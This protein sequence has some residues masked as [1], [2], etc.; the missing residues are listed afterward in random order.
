MRREKKLVVSKE[1]ESSLD[2]V[3]VIQEGS[4]FRYTTSREVCP[5]LPY[6]QVDCAFM[7]LPLN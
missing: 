6:K 5:A 7:R 2:N 1:W 4:G 3:G